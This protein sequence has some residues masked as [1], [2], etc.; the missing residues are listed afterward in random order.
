MRPE[1]PV[2]PGEGSEG[3]SW[4][5][6]TQGPAGGMLRPAPRSSSLRGNHEDKRR[7]SPQRG[8]QPWSAG[9]LGVPWGRRC[10]RSLGVTPE[11]TATPRRGETAAAE[12]MPGGRRPS[13]VRHIEQSGLNMT[14]FLKNPDVALHVHV[15]LSDRDLS[16]TQEAS[17]WPS[18][19]HN[20]KT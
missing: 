19:A 9:D 10:A 8:R 18:C 14:E 17:G 6:G 5:A 12:G 13:T 1:H 7:P 16:L 15:S 2:C 4:T 20:G 11:K 3:C